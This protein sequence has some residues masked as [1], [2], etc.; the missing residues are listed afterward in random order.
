MEIQFE[1]NRDFNQSHRDD[2]QNNEHNEKEGPQGKEGDPNQHLVKRE[3]LDN[4]E[5]ELDRRPADTTDGAKEDEGD[6]TSS[7][8]PGV[9]S[10]N[11]NSTRNSSKPNGEDPNHNAEVENKEDKEKHDG[12]E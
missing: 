12:I 1:Q 9:Q 7:A 2:H 11:Q 6:S 5:K 3:E 4:E 8:I 10:D